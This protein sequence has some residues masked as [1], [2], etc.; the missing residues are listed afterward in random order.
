M[1]LMPTQKVIQTEAVQS[2]IGMQADIY[3]KG[4]GFKIA[5][6]S[7]HNPVLSRVSLFRHAALEKGIDYVLCIDSDHI[8]KAKHLYG[9]VDKMNE[10][11]LDMLSAG[12]LVRGPCQTFAHGSFQEDGSFKQIEKGS[13]SGIVDCDVLGFGFFLFR[14]EFVKK[15]V[16]KHGTDLFKMDYGENSTEDVY[17]CRKMKEDGYRICFDADN[18]VGHLATWVNR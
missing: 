3:N 1:S 14:H 8:Y 5:F 16:D 7:G 9:L 6:T 10:H 11:N 18:I 2:L 4:D 12:Y 15:I 13:V 17:F